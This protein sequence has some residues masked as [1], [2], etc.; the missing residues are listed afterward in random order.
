M[1]SLFFFLSEHSE[2]GS[3]VGRALVKLSI[4]F[5]LQLPHS[6]PPL[7]LTHPLSLCLSP[8]PPL[9]HSII[10]SSLCPGKAHP[11]IG[12]RGLAQGAQG[13]NISTPRANFAEDRGSAL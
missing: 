4:S 3:G 12:G 5:P 10:Y 9:F 7:S 1:V 13:E 6:L 11:H 8:P 2:L